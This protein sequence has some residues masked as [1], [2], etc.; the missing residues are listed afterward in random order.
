MYYSKEEEKILKPFID[1]V[2]T[3]NNKQ[4]IYKFK[5][6]D[7]TEIYVSID[8]TYDSDN[9]LPLED[10][11]Y[12]EYY[13]IGVKILKIIKVGMDV[14]L[15]IGE[16]NEKNLIEINHCNFPDEIYNEK[17]KLISKNK[18]RER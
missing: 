8:C 6:K 16:L 10:K 12:K 7:G 15:Y 2:Y 13:G 9:G 4:E 14:E 1:Y 5:W 3:S 11:H 17:G 18:N